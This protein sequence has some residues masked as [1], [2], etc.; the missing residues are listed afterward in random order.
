[1]ETRAAPEER[2]R[3]AEM[4]V[5]SAEVPKPAVQT[6]ALEMTEADPTI[7]RVQAGLKAF[8]NDG[9]E[10]DGVLGQDTQSAIREFQSLFGL[11]VSGRPDEAFLAK[12]REVGLTN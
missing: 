12:M 2:S 9:I 1:M 10:V 8:G 6:A 11:P 5:P 3:Q 7:M 4:P